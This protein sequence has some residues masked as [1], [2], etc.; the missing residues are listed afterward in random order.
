LSFTSLTTEQI[1]TGE[2]LTN[3]IVTKIKDNFDILDSRI[4]SVEGGSNTVYPP[5][6]F[7]VNGY[8]GEPGELTI[9]ATYYLKT[10]MNF[11]LTVTG[12]RLLIDAA[13]SSGT[14][15]ID[16]KYKR[17][18]GSYTSIFTTLPSVGYAAGN[19]SIST[20]AVLD[21][22]QVALQAGDILAMSI[23][24]AQAG[25]AGFTVRLDYSKT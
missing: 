24:N 2:P 11:N 9:P 23:T 14:T 7:R 21:S 13:G 17:G 19:D 4:T 16:L 15:E 3:S 25:A 8:Y 18:A 12:C 22:G 6:V 5:L 20:N 10:T 1:A